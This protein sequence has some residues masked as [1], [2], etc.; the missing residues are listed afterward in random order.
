[1]KVGNHVPDKMVKFIMTISITCSNMRNNII[2]TCVVHV[3]CRCADKQLYSRIRLDR[4]R[5]ETAHLK[6]A[7]L[8]MEK[9]HENIKTH[10]PMQTD[11]S[12]TLQAF[13]PLFYEAFTK[14]YSGMYIFWLGVTTLKVMFISLVLS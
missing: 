12:E 2:L 14:K 1:M 11:L 13:T 10:I 9:R 4:R 7:L 8:V 3:H 5:F 6:Y